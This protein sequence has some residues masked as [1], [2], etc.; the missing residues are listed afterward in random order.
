[1]SAEVA[2]LQLHKILEAASDCDTDGGRS[3]RL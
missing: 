3:S 1:M 2:A